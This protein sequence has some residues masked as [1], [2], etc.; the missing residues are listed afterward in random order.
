M[1]LGDDRRRVHEPGDDADVAPGP[2]G[3]VEDVVELR[4][5]GDEVV[6]AGLTRLA[7]VLDDAV[8]ELG[9]A[10]LVLHLGREGELALERRRAE[11][12]LALRQDAHEL[13]VPVHLDELDERL[14]VGARHLVARLHQTAILHVGAELVL[15]SA[16]SHGASQPN[17]R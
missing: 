15:V 7:E 9:V 8:D 14:S 10:D 11:D 1:I 5:A 13:R 17:D 2:R 12:P 3:V 6:E 16:V 4:P